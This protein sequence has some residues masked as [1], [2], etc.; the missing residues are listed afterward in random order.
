MRQFVWLPFWP[1]LYQG[2]NIKQQPFGL[3]LVKWIELKSIKLLFHRAAIRL[4]AFMAQTL[5]GQCCN[6]KQQPF[7]IGLANCN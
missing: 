6:I 3:D 4:A 5:P 1:E 2:S 7:G